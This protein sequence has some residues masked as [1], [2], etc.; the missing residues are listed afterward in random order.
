MNNRRTLKRGTF[1]LLL[2]AGAA[3]VGVSTARVSNRAGPSATQGADS[4]ASARA[5]TDASNADAAMESPADAPALAA[6]APQPAAPQPGFILTCDRHV[7]ETQTLSQE[8]QNDRERAVVEVLPNLAGFE[9]WK[10]RYYC[11][12]D[13]DKNNQID[14]AD[15]ALFIEAWSD[16]RHALFHWTDINADGVSDDTDLAD[17]LRL[18][19][20]SPCDPAEQAEYMLQIC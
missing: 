12:G 7:Q 15:I 13:F 17:F 18:M 6:S 14:D 8:A 16:S 1:L 9:Y 11:P 19:H 5:A 2:I 10:Q 4:P 3:A 20:E